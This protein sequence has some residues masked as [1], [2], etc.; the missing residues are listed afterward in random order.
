MFYYYDYI[1][2]EPFYQS[3]GIDLKTIILLLKNEYKNENKKK[4]EKVDNIISK[5]IDEKKI[6]QNN[7]SYQGYVIFEH[8][9]YIK[10]I[11]TELEQN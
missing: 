2:D 11:N 8:K 6:K 5:L 3:N 4:L 9:E 1:M 10:L 7:G